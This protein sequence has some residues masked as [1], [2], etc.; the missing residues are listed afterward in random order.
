MSLEAAR[1]VAKSNVRN[2]KK[3]HLSDGQYSKAWKAL[4]K[5]MFLPCQLPGE[6]GVGVPSCQR[7][8]RTLCRARARSVYRP[9]HTLPLAE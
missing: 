3:T 1:C 4:G 2:V 9:L 8:P 6:G 5:G 7:P